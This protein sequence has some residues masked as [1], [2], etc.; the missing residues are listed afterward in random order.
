MEEFYRE[1]EERQRRWKFLIV[2]GLPEKD[3]RTIE[4]K[5]QADEEA[6]ENIAKAIGVRGLEP[7][8]VSGIGRIN[9]TRPRLL[10]FT[11]ST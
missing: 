7:E 8:E 9:D 5:R 11:C 1:V 3:S 6:I 10:R 2:S 4:E